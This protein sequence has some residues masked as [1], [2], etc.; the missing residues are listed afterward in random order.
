MVKPKRRAVSKPASTTYVSNRERPAPPPQAPPPEE[1]HYTELKGERYME[2][3]RPPRGAH[4]SV[5]E[6]PPDK[7]WLE[8]G[9]QMVNM[10]GLDM[11]TIVGE[12]SACLMLGIHLGGED[13]E[14]HRVWAD[15]QRNCG[16]WGPRIVR[17][18]VK[19]KMGDADERQ[20]GDAEAYLLTLFDRSQHGPQYLRRFAEELRPAVDFI[21]SE[22]RWTRR[23]PVHPADTPVCWA[24]CVPRGLGSARGS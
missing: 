18:I 4:P 24:W 13:E 12:F 10:R 11:F 21:H 9:E 16:D 5:G 22:H 6:W 19:M 20:L 3:L 1:P 23:R 14:T 2:S 17:S 8:M 7:Q 15:V